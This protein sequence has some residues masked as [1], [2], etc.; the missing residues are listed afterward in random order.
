MSS[1]GGVSGNSGAS[2]P[3]TNTVT[4]VYDNRNWTVTTRRKG[5]EKEIQALA[6]D[7]LKKAFAT[8]GEG[9]SFKALRATPKIE[10]GRVTMDIGIEGVGENGSDLH[11]IMKVTTARFIALSSFFGEV[12]PGTNTPVAPVEG[13]G[14]EPVTLTAA[15]AT[16]TPQQAAALKSSKKDALERE[17]EDLLKILKG[18]VFQRTK[19]FNKALDAA[20]GRLQI[21]EAGEDEFLKDF[22]NPQSLRIL[23]QDA[24]RAETQNNKTLKDRLETIIG[25]K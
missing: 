23:I 16:L 3:E 12:M 24:V 18:R 17:V 19:R 25:K 20:V 5:P 21:T 11:T 1:V 2:Q 13:R 14:E 7:I 9:A 22:T 15:P 10:R 6:I 8:A 4:V